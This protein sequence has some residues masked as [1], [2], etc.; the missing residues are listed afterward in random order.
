MSLILLSTAA[1]FAQ[2]T[3]GVATSVTRTVTLTA[4]QADFSLVSGAPI[5]TTQQEV[6]Q[7]LQEGGLSDLTATGTSLTQ[8]YDYST[9]PPATQ[10]LVIYQF[11]FSVPAAQL[12]ATTKVLEK[13]RAKPPALFLLFQYAAGLSASP[14]TVEAMRQTLLPQLFAEAQK[15]AQSLAAAAGL[16]LG[17]VKGVSESFYATGNTWV[18][19]ISATIG[20]SSGS[21]SSTSNTAGTQYTYYT[22]ISYGLG[23]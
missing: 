2:F 5:G 8:V 13:L 14:A 6:I 11:A 22:N 4:D 16:K 10:T 1:V 3:D 18:N 19:Y 7:A 12:G 9:Q 20:N 21:T 15:K 23:Q 17:P